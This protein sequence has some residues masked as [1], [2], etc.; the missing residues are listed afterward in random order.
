MRRVLATSG[1]GLVSLLLAAGAAT[2]S[3]TGTGG[4][5]HD[6]ASG[7][8]TNTFPTGGPAHLMVAAHSDPSGADPTGHVRA[9]GNLFPTEFPG[10][11]TLEG[12][13]TCLRVEP[14]LL[15]GTRAAIKYRFKH[16]EG[17]AAPFQDGGIQIFIEDRGNPDGGQPVDSN[18]FDSPQDEDTFRASMPERCDSPNLRATYDPIESGNYIVH[19]AP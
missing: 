4:E 11:F 7:S 12:E 6:F 2:G 9:K 13:V 14:G 3:H 19:D 15:G 17:S 5:N 8:G 1:L 18:A 16:A 10:P